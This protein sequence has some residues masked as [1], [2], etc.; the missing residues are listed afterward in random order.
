M[1]LEEADFEAQIARVQQELRDLDAQE[2]SP[3]AILQS[4]QLHEELQRLKAELAAFS[5]QTYD[6]KVGED[7]IT[8]V[9]AKAFDLQAT[10]A[11]LENNPVQ[12]EFDLKDAD[13]RRKIAADEA[14]LAKFDGK[15]VTA[16]AQVEIDKAMARLAAYRTQL[17]A[18]DEK[19][20]KSILELDIDDIRADARIR[21]FIERMRLQRK[22]SLPVDVDDRSLAD[23]STRIGRTFARLGN[24]L[25]RVFDD[26]GGAISGVTSNIGS[27]TKGLVSAT[28][29]AVSFA[30][31]ASQ[32]AAI[33]AAIAVAGAAITA[34]WG[35]AATAIAAVPAALA[36]IAAPAA[37]VMLGLDGIKNAAKSIKPEFDALKASIADTFQRGL[38]PVFQQLA[39]LFPKVRD[40]ING[41]ASALVLS[42]QNLTTFITSAT[43]VALI[44]GIFN[45][46]AAAIR[47]MQVGILDTVQALLIMANQTGAFDA[48]TAAVNTFGA[49]FKASVIDLVQSG[50]M[51]A[52]FEG[53]KGT[54]QALARAFV[55]LVDNGIRVFAAAAP[56][57]NHIIESL[58]N[59]F[60]RFDWATLGRAVGGV[61]DGI[62]SAIDKIPQGTI[63]AITAAFVRLGQT[64]QSAGFQQ[65]LRAIID[66]IPTAIGFIDGLVQAFARTAIGIRGAANVITGAVKTIALV[67]QGLADP[68]GLISGKFKEQFDAAG[69]QVNEGLGQIGTAFSSWRPP[70]LDVSPATQAVRDE[71]AKLPPAVQAE[72]SKL[73]S[74]AQTELDK[75]SPAAR[76]A[77]DQLPP[78]AKASL[79]QVP[80][81][82]NEA[83][84]P[85][86]Q[87]QALDGM[88]GQFVAAG[89]ASALA[90]AGGFHLGMQQVAVELQTG[91][92]ALLPIANTAFGQIQQSFVTGM[93]GLAQTVVAGMPAIVAAFNFQNVGNQVGLAFQGMVGT[94][95][96]GMASL[97]ATVAAGMPAITAAFNFQNIGLQVG[98]AF[99]GLVGTVTLGMQSIAATVTA[100][101][102][103]VN[104]AFNFTNIG[105]TVGQA[106]LG[107]VGSVT[108]GM[109]SIV[110]AVQT[111]MLQVQAAF[112]FTN[113]GL[114][115]GLAFQGL[116]GTVTLGMASLAAAVTAG[117]PLISQAFNLTALSETVG[118]AF[119]A[120]VGT[121]NLGMQSI[122][123]SVLSGMATATQA[124]SG[125]M[126]GMA[127]AA[128]A[129]MAG[130]TSAILNG[131]SQSVNAVRAAGAAISAAAQSS[132][133]NFG[134]S[135]RSGMA[136]ATSTVAAGAA[137]MNNLF[138]ALG[139]QIVVTAGQSMAQFATAVT[140][141]MARAVAA[142]VAGVR[143]MT[144]ALQAG[145]GQFFSVGVQMMNGLRGGI[146]SQAGSVAAAAAAVVRGAIAAARAAANTHSPS[147][148]FMEIGSFMGEGLAIGMESSAPR[149]ADAASKMVDAATTTADKIAQAFSGDQWAND[150]NSK[151]EHSFADMSN[152]MSNKDVVGQLRSMNGSASQG[153]VLMSSMIAVLQAILAQGQGGSNVIAATS[154]SRRAA[155]LGA[156]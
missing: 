94:F 26:A 64:F 59:F 126:A 65:G 43:G 41:M 18:L 102:A 38:T 45:R 10:L 156:F 140:A 37:A 122:A 76:A 137:Q 131:M 46:A 144:A 89:Q 95:T 7:G 132:M 4:T 128:A 118:F 48:I 146:L 74:I 85:L 97:A 50:V 154:S 21:A 145:S 120:L 129:G 84:A 77:F 69:A 121:F 116:V 52:A 19:R 30:L 3:E 109:Q 44:E 99:Q 149:V 24:F 20:I 34:A 90:L 104:Q 47:G 139:Q 81:A 111:G 103:L 33:A 135:I 88:E 142:V 49:A 125:G 141:G 5:A 152:T 62:A 12:V 123:Q 2:A 60:N 6:I 17:S 25:T 68:I 67:F 117:M 71:L 110:V 40:E 124:M 112:N 29:S 73:P 28:Q 147:R 16:T 83:L 136:L 91:I 98:L 80:P 106:F 151:I 36:L 79:G 13:L 15:T 134:N 100:N 107:L 148:V 108:L 54:L 113:V 93:V 114:G 23:T 153:T 105:L 82:A 127:Q 115:V 58:T 75:L 138:R 22:I 133:A 39:T 51:Q 92:N 9:R 42:A 86:Q 130:V 55:E 72:L 70:P 119:Q 96:L 150:F 155:E 11:E 56:G 31:A 78:E 35:A 87:L 14:L 101:M 61:F 63:D 57:L 27:I 32:A 1:E 66:L 8:E 143:A 53:L